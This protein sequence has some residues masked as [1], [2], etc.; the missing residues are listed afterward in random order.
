MDV[1]FNLWTFIIP[2]PKK[3]ASPKRRV[4]NPWKGEAGTP[5]APAKNEALV[6]ASRVEDFLWK[7]SRY[8]D[9]SVVQFIPS[10]WPEKDT[11]GNSVVEK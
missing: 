8:P 6:D 4:A 1:R 11:Q 2:I 9:D 5:L 7:S 10:T 3:N